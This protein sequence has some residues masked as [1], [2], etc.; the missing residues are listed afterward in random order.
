MFAG[1]GQVLKIVTF[2][3]NDE[4]KALVQ[5]K[6]IQ[7][8]QNAQQALDGRDIY[9][10]CNTLHIVFSKHTEL[11]VR[12]NNDRSKD[13]TNP[14]LPTTEEPKPRSGM[15]GNGP[16]RDTREANYRSNSPDFRGRGPPEDR[17]RP[18]NY[19]MPPNNRYGAP[20][21]S[22]DARR[23]DIPPHVYDGP[24]SR[25]SFDGPP[26]RNGG[27]D[28]P[29]RPG[30]DNNLRPG[31][32]GPP[33]RMGYDN[34]PRPGYD[35]RPMGP[36]GFNRF[37]GPPPRGFDPRYDRPRSFDPAAPA[38]SGFDDHRYG[39]R[40][41]RPLDPRGR[42]RSNTA[43]PRLSPVLICSNIEK[44]LAVGFSYVYLAAS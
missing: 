5:M 38:R 25:A 30:Y 26:P 43:S 3:K 29:P 11:R 18:R 22:F 15:L 7:E 8:A 12:C 41:R 35:G 17:F 40:D 34:I 32:D 16:R 37:E 20:P 36:P 19:G 31:Y 13:F 24:P 42:D 10:G 27:Y 14:N 39:D 6:E 44:H 4:F 21:D 28:G 2:F 23:G 33:S 1:H 9:T